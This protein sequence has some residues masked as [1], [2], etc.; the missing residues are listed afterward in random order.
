MIVSNKSYRKIMDGDYCMLITLDDKMFFKR[1]RDIWIV[2]D[3]KAIN[4]KICNQDFIN[5]IHK[6]PTSLV[7]DFKN[8]NKCQESK[9]FD[10]CLPVF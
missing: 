4:D 7:D 6:S 9:E 3:M 2:Q 5:V 1:V 8:D 10:V